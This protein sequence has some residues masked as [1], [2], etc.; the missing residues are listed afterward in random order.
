MLLPNR[1]Q[2]RDARRLQCQFRRNCLKSKVLKSLWG[3]PRGKEVLNFSESYRIKQTYFELKMT[4]KP[5]RQIDSVTSQNDKN[6]L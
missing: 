5:I 1:R 2:R 4:K 6:P 3:K